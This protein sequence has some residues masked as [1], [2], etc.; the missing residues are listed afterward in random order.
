[1]LP[2]PGEE[3]HSTVVGFLEEATSGPGGGTGAGQAEKH[4]SGPEWRK[5]T[6]WRQRPIISGNCICL[7]M[8]GGRGQSLQ[9]HLEILSPAMFPKNPASSF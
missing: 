9:P 5:E 3:H 4:G 7:G 6:A 1:M 2:K 8:G